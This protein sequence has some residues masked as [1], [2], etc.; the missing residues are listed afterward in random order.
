[1]GGFGA[2]VVIVVIEGGTNADDINATDESVSDD[3]TSGIFTCLY[4]DVD[5]DLDFRFILD[6]VRCCFG[7]SCMVLDFFF[8]LL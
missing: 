1:M 2:A 6:E 3:N 5:L 8:I 7:W 4:V